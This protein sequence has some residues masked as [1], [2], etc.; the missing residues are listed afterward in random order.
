[1]KLKDALHDYLSPQE[2]ALLVGS[3]DVVGD[4]AIIIIP[5]E[6]EEKET[7][8][9]ETLLGMLKNIQVVAKRD[10][11]VS[12]EF[13][14]TSLKI[15][16]GEKRKETLHRES[17]VIFQLNPEKTYF[18]VRSSNERLR[19]S[20]LVK[21]GEEILVM[22]SGVGAFPLVISNNSEA[23]EIVGIE[24]NHDAHLYAQESYKLNKKVKNVRLIHGDVI[25]IL[26]AL[27]RKF[28][29]IL[30]PL[31]GTAENFLDIALSSLK[32]NGVLHFYDFQIKENFENSTQKVINA[33]F[34]NKRQSTH[35]TV[36][37]CG[38]CSP[39]KYRICVDA[40]VV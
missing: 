22:F 9:G 39:K 32:A 18:S 26:P 19:V 20:R 30:M 11:N 34:V 5:P 38:H 13:R 14:T 27:K 36:T 12:G 8:I 15:I 4:I 33:C 21:Y 28:D 16:A 7:I 25:D 37:V 10:G 6:L 40:Q 23:A 17:G 3:F 35:S 2:R 31:P 24:K 29:R 1:M